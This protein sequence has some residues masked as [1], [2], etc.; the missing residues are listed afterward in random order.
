MGPHL[1]WPILYGIMCPLTI[2][3]SF[4][5]TGGTLMKIEIEQ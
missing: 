5:L 1:R 2:I 3:Q 4:L